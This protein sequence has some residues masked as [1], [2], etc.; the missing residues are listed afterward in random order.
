[1]NVRLIWRAFCETS[2]SETF[3]AGTGAAS[4]G[5]G[6]GVFWFYALSGSPHVPVMAKEYR[7]VAPM[8]AA[9]RYFF[10]PI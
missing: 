1:M 5:P 6:S 9:G 3:T 8:E 2:P 10:L 4:A 7:P